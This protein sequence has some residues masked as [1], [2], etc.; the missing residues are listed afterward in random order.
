MASS[1]LSLEEAEKT[2]ERTQK[3][4]IIQFAGKAVGPLREMP[5]SVEAAERPT[6]GGSSLHKLYYY[7]TVSVIV[8]LN[9]LKEEV[10]ILPLVTCLVLVF[11][12]KMKLIEAV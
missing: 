12:M 7:V 4:P 10:A 6:T 5:L 1:P 3:F 8:K 2:Q 11:Q 9:Y